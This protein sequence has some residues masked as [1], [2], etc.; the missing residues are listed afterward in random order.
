MEARI[1]MKT[2]NIESRCYRTGKYTVCRRFLA[3]FSPEILQAVAVKGLTSHIF[4]S[5]PTSYPP[6]T[7]FFLSNPFTYYSPT[8]A[9]VLLRVVM[10]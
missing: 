4:L 9:R 6:P 5:S 10:T 2:Q 7:T 3:F 8:I 1:I